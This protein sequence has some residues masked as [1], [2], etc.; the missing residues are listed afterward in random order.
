MLS[1]IQVSSENLNL[2]AD[3]VNNVVNVLVVRVA[4]AARGYESSPESTRYVHFAVGTFI[5]SRI[6]RRT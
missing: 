3:Q 4:E 6:W 1:L 2:F 5:R